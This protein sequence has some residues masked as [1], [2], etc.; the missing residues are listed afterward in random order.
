MSRRWRRA[1]PWIVLSLL[2]AA[3]YLALTWGGPWIWTGL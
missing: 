2:C 3:A 1:L